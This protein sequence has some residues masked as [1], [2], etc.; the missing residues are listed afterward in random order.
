M[1]K[2]FVDNLVEVKFFKKEVEL[3]QK[4]NSIAITLNSYYIYCYSIFDSFINEL[5]RYIFIENNDYLK[6][7]EKSI[8]HSKI[9]SIGNHDKIITYIINKDIEDIQRK[10]YIK[11][12]LLFEKMF[13]LP[14]RKFENWSK[15]VENSQRRNII[16]HCNGIV[17]EQ[18]ISVCKENNVDVE[19]NILGQQLKV[20]KN[21]LMETIEL[22]TEIIFKL[23][24]TLWRKIF[25][26]QMKEADIYLA[27]Y[28]YNLLQNKNYK[29]SLTIGDFGVKLPKY[30]N[31]LTKRPI[32][33]NYAIALRETNEVKEL[34]SLL[35]RF[36]WSSTIDDFKVAYSVLKEDY[37]SAY[38][39]LRKIGKVGEFISESAYLAW[40]L[41][42]PLREKPEFQTLFE[43]VYGKSIEAALK[44]GFEKSI[45]E[46]IDITA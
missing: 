35:D 19:D 34:N 26:E 27:N 41:F 23:G 6:S 7:D 40:P 43:E 13:E 16:V 45:D 37:N 1:F 44:D 31:D 33:V 3:Y 12:F 36:D 17:S 8:S 32:L 30:F 25:P 24:Q 20:D 5:L 9:L 10:S 2:I 46:N 28:I 18:Y 15:F 11:Q 14:L 42:I 4:S 39:L 21:Y 22:L 29:L 38:R